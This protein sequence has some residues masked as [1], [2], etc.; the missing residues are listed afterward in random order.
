MAP[1]GLNA[2]TSA[3]TARQIHDRVGEILASAAIRSLPT[4]D[5]LVTWGRQGPILYHTISVSPSAVSSSLV[6]NDPFAGVLRTTWTGG[7]PS[8]FSVQWRQGDRTLADFVGTIRNGN[9]V[10]SGSRTDSLPIPMSTWAIA[11]HGMDEHLVPAVLALR[12]D[13]AI[14]PITVLR[15]FAM[16]WD[17]VWVTI[18][19]QH[20]LLNIVLNADAKVATRLRLTDAGRLLHASQLDGSS[21]LRPL[22]FTPLASEYG[23]LMQAAAQR[24]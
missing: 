17:T 24:P 2:Q 5:T 8:G 13:G 19:R 14:H 15:P 12:A 16:K 7:Q 9:L 18:T 23:R 22:E 10:V 3:P 11:D 20:G 6:R 4:G 1:L 21:E